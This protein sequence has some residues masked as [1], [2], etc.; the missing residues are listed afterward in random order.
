MV[1][2][3]PE[4]AVPETGRF[5]AGH[6][7]FLSGRLENFILEREIEVEDGSLFHCESEVGKQRREKE[8]VIIV[9]FIYY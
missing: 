2:R 4:A 5:Y 6:R 7:K 1:L 9:V 3:R 8:S